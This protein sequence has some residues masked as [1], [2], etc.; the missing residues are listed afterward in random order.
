MNRRKS[1]GIA[2]MT[3]VIASAVNLSVHATT[4]TSGLVGQWQ[5]NEPSG[6]TAYDSSG[7][8]HDGAVV[9]AASFAT[10]PKKG[11]VVNVYAISGEVDLPVTPDLQPVTGTISVWVKPTV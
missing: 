6:V 2:A 3:L 1:F 10:D 9:G 8:G 4:I 7:L 11:N 5:F